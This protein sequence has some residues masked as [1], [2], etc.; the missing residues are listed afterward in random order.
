MLAAFCQTRKLQALLHHAVR[1]DVFVP[2]IFVH[3]SLTL[4]KM[5]SNCWTHVAIGLWRAKVTK[6]GVKKCQFSPTCIAA[7]LHWCHG[8]FGVATSVRA[9]E[10]GGRPDLDHLLQGLKP[11]N[12]ADFFFD[13]SR[14]GQGRCRAND[15]DR[16]LQLVARQGFYS[17]C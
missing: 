15:F 8:C 17:H 5:K 10:H 1:A 13:H 12:S 11:S 3:P 7:W 6:L 16:A 2:C 14:A 9:D 4:R